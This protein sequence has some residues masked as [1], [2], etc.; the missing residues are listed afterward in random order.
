MEIRVDA[1]LLEHLVE[2]AQGELSTSLSFRTEIDN[3][4]SG[5]KGKERI[6]EEALNSARDYI[7]YSFRKELSGKRFSSPFALLTSYV[8]LL[9]KSEEATL[10]AISGVPA[11]EKDRIISQIRGKLQSLLLEFKGITEFEKTVGERD[12][13]WE[14]WGEGA[15]LEELSDLTWRRLKV[16]LRAELKERRLKRDRLNLL[17]H[18]KRGAITRFQSKRLEDTLS[19]IYDGE[20]GNSIL[21]DLALGLQ[22]QSSRTEGRR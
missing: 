18:V 22:I 17:D 12:S 11:R 13:L 1:D 6:L 3:L 15:G 14:V 16:R 10:N 9:S 5:K 2:R 4:L 19:R 7:A 21:R 20:Q 8:D